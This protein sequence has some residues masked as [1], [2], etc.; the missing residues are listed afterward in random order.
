[1]KKKNIYRNLLLV[2]GG[3]FVLVD[4]GPVLVAMLILE[5]SSSQIKFPV[6]SFD[7]N[8]DSERAAHNLGFLEDLSAMRAY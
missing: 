3:H 1:M 6:N 7:F 2:D 4:V 5:Q 8:K